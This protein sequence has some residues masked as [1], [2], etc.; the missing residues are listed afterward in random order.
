L[1]ATTAILCA[2]IDVDPN[3]HLVHLGTM[4]VYGYGSIPGMTI[5]EGYMDVL[6]PQNGELHP[7]RIIHPANPGSVYHTTKTQDHLLFQFFAKN[8]LL[9]ITDLHQGI[10]WGTFT[11]ETQLDPRLTNRFDYDG[12]YGTVLNRFI[13]QAAVKQPMTV[14]GT[15]GQTRAFIH[16]RDAIRCFELSIEN[17]PARGDSVLIR[18]QV[19]E[20]HNVLD[21]AHLV[22]RL[23]GAELQFIENPR[24]E[25]ESN[26]LSVDNAKFLALNLQPTKLADGLVL[27]VFELAT[28]YA[29]NHLNIKAILPCSKWVK[30]P[31]AKA[32][33]K[34]LIPSIDAKLHALKE[35]GHFHGHA[36]GQKKVLENEKSD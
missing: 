8:D 21:L 15:G 3:I 22:S 30:D 20:T 18:N 2:I 10:V 4:G 16:I 26:T 23:T 13:M 11:E 25:S 5:P 1:T 31:T 32:F 27:E 6:V 17:P 24:K 9:R 19:T 34:P 12:D 7:L 29:D 36:N 28:R 33:A 35:N 14:Y